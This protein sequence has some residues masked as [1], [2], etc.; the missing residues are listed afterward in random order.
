MLTRFRLVQFS[1]YQ[2]TFVHLVQIIFI[3]E[4]YLY[5]LLVYSWL[6]EPAK[7]TWYI[8]I[9]IFNFKYFLY[10]SSAKHP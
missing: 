7:T 6:L 8:K 2:K 1:Y 4:N 3:D 5:F 9:P 10:R